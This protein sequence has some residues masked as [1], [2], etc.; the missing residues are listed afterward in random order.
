VPK[1]NDQVKSAHNDAIIAKECY[2]AWVSDQKPR[3][4]KKFVDQHYADC[5]AASLIEN[6]PTYNFWKLVKN[7]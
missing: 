3:T 2:L 7:N 4:S 5:L 1:W 6:H